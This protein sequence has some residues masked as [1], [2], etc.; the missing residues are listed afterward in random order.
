MIRV[1]APS[2]LHFG[3]LS[4]PGAERWTN[5]L[6]DL[7]LPARWFGG[8]GLM[9]EEPGLQ[10]TFRAAPDWKVDGPLADRALGFVRRIAPVLPSAGFPAQH[11]TIERASPEHSG[12]GT[13]TQ[14]GMAVARGLVAAAGLAAMPA[15]DL[16]LIAHRGV[17]SAV[18][19][20]GF[21]EGGFLV[22]AG[23]REA[24]KVAPLITRLPF[25]ESWRIVLV[26]PPWAPGLHGGEETDAFGRV[27]T[28]PL[29]LSV[30]D[31]LCRLILLGMLPALAERDLD[32]FGE[33]VHDFNARAGL[34][35]AAVQHGTYAH[36]RTT[37]L[38]TFIRRQ[39]IRGVGQSSWG[40]A[41][42]AF[43]RNDGEAH[44]L[45]SRIQKEFAFGDSE[46]RITRACN[47]GAEIQEG[48]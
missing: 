28:N 16:A 41:V 43:A 32:S 14:L 21:A 44:H 11:L 38:I 40:P 30:T 9:I 18:G 33:A 37:D 36:P 27:R 26:L 39:G 47:H 15:S 22:E 48:L 29:P 24:S 12:L 35:F 13:G 6:G 5:H 8:A 17:R 7:V 1:T 2:R 19:V 3:L 20:H 31:A 42:F 23:K 10:I 46:V 45:R 25:P 4:L 34:A